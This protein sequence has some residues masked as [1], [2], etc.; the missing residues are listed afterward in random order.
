MP[1]LPGE[2]E[3]NRGLVELQGSQ[4][5][6]ECP[7]SRH[8][9]DVPVPLERERGDPQLRGLAD[10]LLYLGSGRVLVKH[11]DLPRAVAHIL[12]GVEMVGLGRAG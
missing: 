12:R 7:G 11:L 5:A 1:R 6:P 9:L 10:P 2:W 4:P 3:A 8:R